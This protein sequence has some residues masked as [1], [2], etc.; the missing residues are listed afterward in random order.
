ME[1]RLQTGK[2]L[3][4]SY[5]IVEQYI[6][7]ISGQVTCE[8]PIA[9]EEIYR[10]EKEYF[11]EKAIANA[12]AELPGAS[13]TESAKL[14]SKIRSARRQQTLWWPRKPFI[15]L[16]GL[17]VRKPDT[18]EEILITENSEVQKSLVHCWKPVYAHKDT[19][20]DLTAKLLGIY[21]RK[22]SSLFQFS[23]IGI[24]DEEE[25]ADIIAHSKHSAPGVDGVPYGAYKYIAR[26]VAPALR[27]VAHLFSLG[28]PSND[29]LSDELYRYDF[30]PSPAPFPPTSISMNDFLFSF[31]KKK[32]GF[33][34][35]GIGGG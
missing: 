14:K 16:Q 19:N 22:Q 35:E 3:I 10:S 34:F 21:R 1:Q 9:F 29:T 2:N 32:G 30:P 7:I 26:V 17:R 11:Q 25:I 6:E 15:K 23:D 24:P 31:N 18:V 13:I 28:E 33:Y 27:N 5:E 12:T 20:D 8:D 4:E